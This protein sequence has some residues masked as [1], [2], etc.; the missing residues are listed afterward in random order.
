VEKEAFDLVLM[1]VHMPVLDG[2]AA[3]QTIRA[4]GKSKLPI[5]AL[6]ASGSPE[7]VR[8]CL[9]AGMDGHLL[10]PISPDELEAVLARVFDGAR[11]AEGQEPDPAGDREDE[12]VSQAA[13]EESMGRE[14]TLMFVRMAQ[15]QLTGRFAS[16]ERD[17]IRA[18]AHKMA[19]SA[20]MVGLHR[21]GDAARR[22]EDACRDDEEIAPALAVVRGALADAET[23]LA[24]WAA[25]LE[26]PPA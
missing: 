7:Q 23:T 9:D 22:L 20:G 10:K 8:A 16:E 1:D 19:G 2:L 3:T 14:S 12:L 15:E 5:F 11:P 18:D 6:T 17:A 26:R 13:F 21:L 4:S 24:A 25:R